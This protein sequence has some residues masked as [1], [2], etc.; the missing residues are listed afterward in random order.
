M[1]NYFIV[2]TKQL[3]SEIFSVKNGKV[4]FQTDEAII[5]R[6]WDNY[7]VPFV[8]GWFAANGKFRSDDAKVGDILALVGSTTSATYCPSQ[9]MIDD[10]EPY[11]IES[12]TLPA[13]SFEG[14]SPCQVQQGAGM[15][16]TK[17]T[18]EEEFA[19][20]EFLKWFTEED[21]NMSFSISSGYLPVKTSATTMSKL[22]TALV[23]SKES[24]SPKLEETLKV[25]FQVASTQP[26][27]T[28]RAFEGG[29]AARN[30]LENS[31]ADKAAADAQKVQELVNGGMSR[32]DAA[33]TMTTDENFHSWYTAF[34]QALEE[35]QKGS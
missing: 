34:M 24:V 13:P 31:M 11:D 10:S 29:T 8:N 20:V 2:G 7:Y 16:V 4:T 22:E 18:P 19:S 9:V 23:N 33:A 28:N 26:L 32:S 1:A 25:A 30:V 6:L 35:T 3:G 21:R 27:Y 12:I 5:R 15:V 17:S 14:G